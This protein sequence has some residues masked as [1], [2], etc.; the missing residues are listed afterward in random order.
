M[1]I[2]SRRPPLSA[3]CPCTAGANPTGAS[4]PSVMAAGRIRFAKFGLLFI[5]TS[6]FKY[7]IF[8]ITNMPTQTRFI[9]IK[10]ELAFVHKRRICIGH[11][12]VHSKYRLFRSISRPLGA[13]RPFEPKCVKKNVFPRNLYCR[14][15][16]EIY[17]NRCR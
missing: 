2:S 4:R 10:L 12:K 9:I 3:S 16:I 13:Q 6:P 1:M 17:S 5:Y 14:E 7:Q 15:L 11:L 8:F